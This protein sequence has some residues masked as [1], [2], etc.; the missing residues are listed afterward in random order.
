MFGLGY[1]G[2]EASEPGSWGLTARYYHQGRGTYLAH[3]IDGETGFATGF[4]GWSI[5]GDVTVAKNMV[6]SATY[7]DT[8]ALKGEQEEN[9]KAKVVWTEFN[10]YF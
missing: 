10:V 8:K 5:G 2:A 3:T 9:E 4:K 6:L 1:K 7:Y